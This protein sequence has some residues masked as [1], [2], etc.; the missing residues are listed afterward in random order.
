MA[1]SN[2]TTYVV[3]MYDSENKTISIS[4]EIGRHKYRITGKV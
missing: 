2:E 3:I 1:K 4:L